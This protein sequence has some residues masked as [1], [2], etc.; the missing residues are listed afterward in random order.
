MQQVAEAGRGAE[1]GSLRGTRGNKSAFSGSRLCP[2][3]AL[4]SHHPR[5]RGRP[6]GEGARSACPGFPA[7]SRPS[8]SLKSA[9]RRGHLIPG[10]PAVGARLRRLRPRVGAAP[11]ERGSVTCPPSGPPGRA[12]PCSRRRGR[13]RPRPPPP[14]LLC[15]WAL[16]GE[17]A[18][19]QAWPRSPPWGRGPT[20][21]PPAPALRYP[22]LP[23]P[24]PCH[25]PTGGR[26]MWAG[27]TALLG[28]LQ[29]RPSGPTASSAAISRRT[30]VLRARCSLALSQPKPRCRGLPSCA[31]LPSRSPARALMSGT[32]LFP[33]RRFDAVPEHPRLP[34]LGLSPRPPHTLPCL[35]QAGARLNSL[36]PPHLLPA[37]F[38]FPSRARTRPWRHPP[39]RAVPTPARRSHGPRPPLPA[40]HSPGS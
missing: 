17:G 7:R 14:A 3:S 15:P 24:C 35:L 27:S 1:E 29:P 11:T 28:L 16:P 26:G 37:G 25:R 6:E 9:G 2:N 31:P 23:P 5:G 39:P 34:S 32:R 19:G 40:P 36:P 10:G 38:T 12:G 4:A 21:P 13:D 20:A 8:W 30:R 33:A 18:L 22:L